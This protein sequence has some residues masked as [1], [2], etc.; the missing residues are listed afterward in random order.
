M[1]FEEFEKLHRDLCERAL[2][3]SRQKGHDY[4]G[5]KDTLRNLKNT[6]TLSGGAVSAEQGV[7]VRMGDKLSRLWSLL[8][9]L[10]SD[11]WVKD[12]SMEDT[13]LDMVNYSILLVALLRES[14]PPAA[15]SGGGA[16]GTARGRRRNGTGFLVGG[17]VAD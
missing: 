4:S 7:L 17:P 8:S 15:P 12:E 5:T 9:G 11:A 14:A 13:L 10:D 1:R 2:E 3:I 16:E 6:G